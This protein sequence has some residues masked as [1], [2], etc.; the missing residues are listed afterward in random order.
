MKVCQSPTD[1]WI[2]LCRR[3]RTT[4]RKAYIEHAL[5]TRGNG[6][7]GTIPSAEMVARVQLRQRDREAPV[8]FVDWQWIGASQR[9]VAAVQLIK[10]TL[11][12]PGSCRMGG[13][14]GRHHMQAHE[15]LLLD[16][17]PHV[18]ATI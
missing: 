5:C 7:R 16:H 9:P 4:S 13:F 15:A 10:R 18:G 12:L 17:Q 14:A 1:C 3:V 6:V 8:L 2:E 11:T